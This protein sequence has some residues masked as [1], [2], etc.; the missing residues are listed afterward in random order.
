MLRQRG[1]VLALG[2]RSDGYPVA[3]LLSLARRSASA[4]VNGAMAGE[5]LVLS[6]WSPRNGSGH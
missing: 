4:R 3:F 5:W 6:A 2:C 1:R